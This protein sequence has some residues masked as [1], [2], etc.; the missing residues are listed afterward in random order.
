MT[1]LNMTKRTRI[2][3]LVVVVS[4]EPQRLA[5]VPSLVSRAYL[6]QLLPHLGYRRVVLPSYP[7]EQRGMIYCKESQNQ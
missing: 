1:K 2:P 7:L 6:Q 5:V 4:Q 3:S